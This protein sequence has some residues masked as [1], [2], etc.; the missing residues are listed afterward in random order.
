[1][2]RSWADIFGVF[3]GPTDLAS[4]LGVSRSHASVM[5][6]RGSIPSS[7]W[8]KLRAS[9]RIDVPIER[10]LELSA[11]PSADWRTGSRHEDAVAAKREILGGLA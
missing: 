5:R 8:T 7:Y 3:D 11:K 1:M 4:T 6:R 10:L 2:M 9:E